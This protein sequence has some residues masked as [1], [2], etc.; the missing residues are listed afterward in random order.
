MIT[1][2]LSIAVAPV[3]VMQAPRLVAGAPGLAP[4]ERLLDGHDT[5]PVQDAPVDMQDHVIVA[6]LGVGGSIV[7]KAL[8]AAGVPAL[9]VDLQPAT[10]TRQA[11]L[12]RKVVYGDITSPEVQHIAGIGS[13]RA[14]VL[15]ISDLRASHRA[16][17]VA[18][19]LRPTIPILIWTRYASEEGAERGKG[20]RVVSEE[21]AAAMGL[22]RMLLPL[23]T[24]KDLD[25]VLAPIL[26]E[27]QSLGAGDEDHL[28]APVARA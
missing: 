23:V 17:E 28:D 18:R 2:V 1:A 15:V 27:H 3:V 8:E 20:V 22:C 19:E 12:G 7:V 11:R 25:A 26:R 9:L 13:A 10:L 24:D 5:P 14:L 16:L 4:L 21:F 6:G